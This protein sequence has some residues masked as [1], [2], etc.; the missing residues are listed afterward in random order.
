MGGARPPA[1]GRAGPPA[2]SSPH[3]PAGPDTVVPV[4]TAA[5]K[6]PAELAAPGGTVAE[7]K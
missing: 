5:C 7:I 6:S 4:L 1:A 3:P 2:L